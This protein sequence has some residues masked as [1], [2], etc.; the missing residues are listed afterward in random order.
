[1]EEEGGLKFRVEENNNNTATARVMDRPRLP[2][3]AVTLSQPC[4][5]AGAYI[6]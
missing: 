2:S 4:C 5:W 3:L 6:D 1:M